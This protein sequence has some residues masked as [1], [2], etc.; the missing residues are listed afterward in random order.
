MDRVP[1]ELVPASARPGDLLYG[2]DSN[3][4]L[5][6]AN[7]AWRVFAR[8]NGGE[9][10]LAPEWHG[11]ALT[12]FSGSEKLRWRGIYSALLE[13]R[14]ASHEEEFICSSPLERRDYRLRITAL[15]DPGGQMTCLLHHTARQ[16]SSEAARAAAS[17]R[18]KGSELATAYH[19]AVLNRVA[20]A[21]SFRVAQCLVPLEDI[22]GDLL[23]HFE[24]PDGST[25]IV[26]ADAMGHG[27]DA[28]R[29]AVR[30]T[31]LLDDLAPASG[32]VSAKVSSL[33]R[34][35]LQ[36]RSGALRTDPGFAT[37][38]YLRLH[39]QE[40]R[41][42]VCSFAHEGPIFSNSG[43]VSVPTGFPVGMVTEIEPWP[44]LS[45][46]LQQLGPRFLLCSDG[47]TEQFNPEGEMFGAQRIE[48][49]FLRGRE[50]PL[51]GL[52]PAL[53]A[54]I[55]GFRGSA[56]VKDDCSLLAVELTPEHAPR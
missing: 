50:L 5:L 47:M 48:Q 18:A 38:L 45:L 54:R 56:L 14:L 12:G 55:D 46:D 52:V 7:E 17:S 30:I 11:D 22:G 1:E 6:C 40:S 35:L 9:Q 44:E 41:V 24:R 32:R 21:R 20:R 43:R 39:P 23:W 10:L 8:A 26:F 31:E 51:S 33:N 28:A 27:A 37:G 49:F 29:F 2:L 3:L 34:A 53:L 13:G 4:Q 16:E 19:A 42:D 25:D 15:R 36:Q